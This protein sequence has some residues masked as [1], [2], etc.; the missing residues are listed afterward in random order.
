[1]LG[2]R[3][4]SF[5]ALLIFGLNLPS[6]HSAAQSIEGFKVGDDMRTAAKTHPRPSVVGPQGS[7]AA[8]RWNEAGRNTVSVTASP[9][10]GKIVFIESDWGG[11]ATF[12]ASALLGLTFGTST[13]G[14]IGDKF[15]SNGFG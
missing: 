3:I 9:D 4:A 1:M 2:H 6:G 10:T 7:Y 5:A 12:A 14:D 11:D 13:L 8:F 15:G